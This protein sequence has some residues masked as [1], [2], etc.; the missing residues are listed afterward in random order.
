MGK[1]EKQHKIKTVAF[2]KFMLSKSC[3]EIKKE[4]KLLNY[5]IKDIR[6]K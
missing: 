3:I 5:F 1:R 2:D 4:N 6:L